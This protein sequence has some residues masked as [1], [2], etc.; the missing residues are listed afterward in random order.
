MAKTNLDGHTTYIHQS[1]IVTTMSHS[2]QVGSTQIKKGNSS[3][4]TGDKVTVL[5]LYM[6]LYQCIKFHLI[7]TVN[8]FRDI[9]RQKSATEGWMS[10][11]TDKEVSICS[12]FRVHKKFYFDF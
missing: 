11:W 6:A 2:P 4:N 7:V 5:A 12:P 8:T 9:L 3:V 10:R 1:E